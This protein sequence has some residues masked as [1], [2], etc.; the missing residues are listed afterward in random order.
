MFVSGSVSCTCEHD[1]PLAL[2][3]HAS[4]FFARQRVRRLEHEAVDVVALLKVGLLFWCLFLLEVRFDKR[5]LYVG[6]LGVQVFG[7]NL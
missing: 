4:M 3:L 7:I 5:H 2:L 1:P 6:E